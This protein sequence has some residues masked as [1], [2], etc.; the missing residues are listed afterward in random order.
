[1]TATLLHPLH[2]ERGARLTPDGLLL[3]FGDVPG[4]YR[5]GTEGCALFDRT[6]RGRVRVAGGDREE[7]LHR[8]LANRVKG[9]EPG[10]GCAN[11]L[12][13]SK[14]KVVQAFELVAEDD[15]FVLDVWPEQAP[16]LITALD[17]YLFTDDVQL[18]DV[19]RS[20]APLGL[21]GLQAE[22][23]VR[24]L[25]PELPEL[26][27]HGVHQAT[28]QGAPLG[29][30]RRAVAGSEGYEVDAGPE[31][32]R[33]LWD[34]LVAAGATPA[35][36]VAEDCLRVEAC[37]AEFGVDIDENVYPQE[38]RLEGAFS[39]DKGCYIGQEVVA[40]IDTYGGLN[41]C[42]MALRIDHDDP[43]PR[44]T[45]LTV[46]DAERG[47]REVGIVTSWAYSFV[48]DTGLALGQVKRRHQQ[49]G[50]QLGLEGREGRATIVRM[51]VREGGLPVTG[52]QEA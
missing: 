9:L 16:A 37:Q 52:D 25:V 29:I 20:T 40:K 26:T 42:M 31:R 1:M 15:G 17:L 41:K 46:P 21:C 4:E 8:L 47:T 2:R 3:T 23:V 6:D 12:L 24:T 38:A 27:M 44:G 28:F 45:R 51:P 32:A 36:R 34:A 33:A 18:E 7:F 48:L 11:L 5:A 50:T 14:G 30:A 43:L 35:G 49:L 22:R 19:S 13:T 39:L 10:E